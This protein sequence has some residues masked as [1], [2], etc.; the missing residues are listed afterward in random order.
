MWRG[1][2]CGVTSRHTGPAMKGKNRIRLLIA[3]L[4]GTLLLSTGLNFYFLLRL[5]DRALGQE[6]ETQLREPPDT[7]RLPPVSLQIPSVPPDTMLLARP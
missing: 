4:L 1:V 7:A 3:L 5:D 2:L 6:L